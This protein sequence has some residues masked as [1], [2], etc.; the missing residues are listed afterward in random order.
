MNALIIRPDEEKTTPEIM[1]DKA[2]DRFEISGNSLP[3]DVLAFYTPVIKWIEEYK[4]QPNP[5]TKLK[6]RLNYFNSASSKI[7]LDLLTMFEELQQTGK[8]VVIEWH[9]LDM[10]E[11]MLATGQEFQ[12]LIK[13]PFEFLPFM[14]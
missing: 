4:K 12:S 7:I 2:N 14:E 9:Y 5:T 8:N 11:D 13:I 1:L 6:V 3:E 10:D